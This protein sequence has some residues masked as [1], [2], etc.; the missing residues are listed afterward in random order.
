LARILFADNEREQLRVF[1]LLLESSGHEVL[2]AASPAEV[3][4]LLDGTPP[5]VLIVDLR[6]PTYEQGVA[7]LRNIRTSGYD[8]PVILLSGWPDEFL[9]SPDEKLVN[10]VMM[11]PARIPDLLEAIDQLTNKS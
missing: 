9:D 2:L 7:L 4:A 11:K 3:L 6:F 8:K 5:D 10:R 1:Q